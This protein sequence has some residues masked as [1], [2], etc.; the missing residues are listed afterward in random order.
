MMPMADGDQPRRWLTLIAMTGSLSMI[1]IDV[2]VVGVALPQ[3][4]ADLGMGDATIQWVVTI[5]TLVMA[6]SVALCGRAADAVGR[7]PAFVA[8]VIIFAIAS[9]ACG[10]ATSAGMLIAARAI[11]GA[12]AALMQPA[13]SALVIGAFAPGSRGKAMGV[14]VGIP[15]LFMVV[16]PLIG[17]AITEAASWRWC[18]WVNL[19]IALAALVMTAVAR[20]ADRRGPPRR[21]DPIAAALLVLGLPALVLGVQQ[22]PEWGWLA[23]WLG[24]TEFLAARAISG[25]PL[26]LTGAM[27]LVFFVRSQWRAAEP[28]LAVGLFRDRGLLANAIVLFLMQFSMTGLLIQGSVYAQE[29]L[30]FEPRRAGASLLPLLVPTLFVVHVAGRLY[31]R[32]GVRTPSMIGTALASIGGL[33]A[34]AGAW[35]QSY[36]IIACG[37]VVMGCGIGFVMSPTST[38]SLSRVPAE[39]RAQVSGLMQTMRHVGGTTGLAVIGATVLALRAPPHDMLRPGVGAAPTDSGVVITLAPEAASSFATAVAVGYAVGALSCAAALL[40]AAILHRRAGREVAA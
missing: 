24:G 39:A 30:L 28:L 14:Y 1:F 21:V 35:Q 18:F 16:G 20:P 5:Y 34:G 29:V 8:G 33:V 13:S 22:G 15:L 9:V 27:L 36:P 19:P 40:A 12:G 25:L 7:V 38:D 37:F 10:S 32:V 23:P 11:Q 31:D 3:I 17:G 4:Q 26:A 2:T 6:C